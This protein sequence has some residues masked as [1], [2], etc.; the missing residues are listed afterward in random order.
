MKA[1][2]E[3][4]KKSR[5]SEHVSKVLIQMIKDKVLNTGD[6]LPSER[7]L[8][9]QFQVGRASIREALKVMENIGYVES[10]VGV[11]GGTFVRE[12]TIES[13]IDP[14]AD[15][16]EN[17]KD[18]ILE[19]LDFRL[20]IE[21]EFARIA[22]VEYTDSDINAIK[23]SLE[24]MKQEIEDGSIGLNGDNEF[25]EAVVRA[26][27]N[28][29]FEKMLLMSKSL[30]SRTRETTLQIE[31][32]PESS[33]A[34]HKEIYEAIRSRNADAAADLMNQHIRKAR[35]NALYIQNK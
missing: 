12:I 1:S 23:H 2:I 17:E 18:M 20:I 14:F 28:N 13:I 4:I 31:N 32:Q 10:R 19:M 34:D 11:T 29:V 3:P 15:F 21:T 27:H 25:H 6:Q 35:E 7:E 8:A 16:L 22:A 9:E 33:L 5:L 30:L 24:H 26:T